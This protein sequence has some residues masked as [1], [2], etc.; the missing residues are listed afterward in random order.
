MQPWEIRTQFTAWQQLRDLSIRTRYIDDLWN[1]LVDRAAFEAITKLI[2]PAQYGLL[3]GDPESDGPSVDYLDLTVW[4]D[5]KSHQWH[6]KLYV[7]KVAM[8]AKGLKLNKFPDPASKLSTRCKYGVIISQLHRYDMVW[9]HH[10]HEPAPSTIWCHH[11]PAPLLRCSIITSQLHCYD[12]A[13]TR[14]CDFLV[15]AQQ[16]YRTY[17]QKGYHRQKVHPYLGRFLRRHVPH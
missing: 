11:E 9:C 14:R 6:S 10:N 4:C 15:P 17:I 2:Y 7:K 12:V 16:L 8:V 5:A 1:P 13:C 3:L